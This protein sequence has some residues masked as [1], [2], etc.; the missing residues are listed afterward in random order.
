MPKFSLRDLL[1]GVFLIAVMLA[2]MLPMIQQAREAA[3]RMSCSTNAKQVMLAIHNYESSFGQLPQAMGGTAGNGYRLSGLVPLVPFMESNSLW[4]EITNPLP[5]GTV[6]YPSMGPSPTDKR[7]PPWR[8][9]FLP[10]QC[11]T[12]VD[13]D[14]E[15]VSKFGRSNYTF[16]IGDIAKNIHR[17]KSMNQVRG[18]FSPRV[19]TRFRDITD[20]LS[21]TIA[22]AEIA[23]RRGRHKQGQFVVDESPSV[24]DRP[25]DCLKLLDPKS[26]N[27]YSANKTLSLLG[28]GA[29]WADGAA[30]HALVNTILPP[31]SPSCG[32]SVTPSD[33]IFSAGSYHVG[34]CHVLM[35]DGA[36]R[37]MTESVDTGDLSASP[38]TTVLDSDSNPIQSPYGVW[39]AMGTR[40]SEEDLGSDIFLD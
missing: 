17:P 5:V 37:F 11:P 25:S 9:N 33:G 1:I 32:V 31:N 4:G 15:A 19:V 10:Y 21:N 28:R 8:A 22:A 23:N 27:Y 29:I 3:R 35:G 18:T 36:V 38:P 12:S 40:A 24:L 34:G 14:G 39:G 7:Y 13:F 6:L 26:P 2:V 20:G 16:C 30:G